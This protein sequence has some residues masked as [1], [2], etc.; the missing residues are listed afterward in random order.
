MKEFDKNQNEGKTESKECGRQE[1]K[2]NWR[3]ILQRK[4]NILLIILV[5]ILLMLIGWP[6]GE[7]EGLNNTDIGTARIDFDAGMQQGEALE[8]CGL[9]QRL[10]HLLRQI[11]GCE[12]LE[13]MITFAQDTEPIGSLSSSYDYT[14]SYPEVIGVVILTKYGGNTK[15]KERISRIVQA[16][17]G[18]ETHKIEVIS[19]SF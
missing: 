4:E 17:F 11:E 16:L 5:G 14:Y 10:K 9:E 12:D 15:V 7:K 3:E 18:T 2:A 6:I 1:S 8:G 13:V 19:N